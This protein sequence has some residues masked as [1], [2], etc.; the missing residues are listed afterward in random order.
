MRSHKRI[1]SLLLVMLMVVGV[2]LTFVMADAAT[3][4]NVSITSD[5][6][7]HHGKVMLLMS[8]SAPSRRS[9]SSGA[10]CGTLTIQLSSFT[11]MRLITIPSA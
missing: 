3:F 8:A 2:F 9:R 5:S 11:I 1:L 4:V 7:C 6:A 10:A